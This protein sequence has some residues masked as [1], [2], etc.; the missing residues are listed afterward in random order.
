MDTETI[1]NT[2]IDLWNE[3]DEAQR[4]AMLRRSW[5]AEVA[6]RDPLMHAKGRTELS[7][8]VAGIQAQF[9]EFRFRRAGASDSSGDCVRFSWEMGPEGGEAPIAGTD[10]IELD[11]SGA[12]ARV[13]GF[14][15]RLPEGEQA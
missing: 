2:Y 10:V 6:Y 15:D 8:L 12:I 7:G 9:P 4:Q 5:S 13:I 14:L 1:A 3:T 11:H